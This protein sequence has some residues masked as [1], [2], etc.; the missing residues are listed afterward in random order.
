MA[1][2]FTDDQSALHDTLRT[3]FEEES[4]TAAVRAAEAVRHG[5]RAAPLQRHPR[6]PGP[7]GAYWPRTRPAPPRAAGSRRAFR[8]A[9]VG[10]IYGGTSEIL[11]EIVAE[12]HLRLPRNR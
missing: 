10:T 11:R 4:S 7:R 1:L 8:A 6:H 3:F 2:D 12:R 5:G 9:A